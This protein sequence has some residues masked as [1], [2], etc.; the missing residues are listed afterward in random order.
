MPLVSAY[1]VFRFTIIN[2]KSLIKNNNNSNNS[3]NNNYNNSININN[4]NE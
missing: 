4:N 1:I 3:N 2:K